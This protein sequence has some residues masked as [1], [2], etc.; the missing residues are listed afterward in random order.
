MD[1]SDG[2]WVSFAHDHFISDLVS[3]SEMMNDG[4]EEKSRCV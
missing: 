4:K 2:L 1:E 3:W